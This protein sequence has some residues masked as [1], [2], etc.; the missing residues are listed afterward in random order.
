MAR[1]F[2][3][4]KANQAITVTAH[5]PPSAAFGSSFGVA[6]TAPA[7]PVTFSSSGSCSN[8]GSTCTMTSGSGTCTVRYDQAGNGNYNAADRVTE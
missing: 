7:G 6:A 5:A 4:A 1:S 3:I 2:T 8:S